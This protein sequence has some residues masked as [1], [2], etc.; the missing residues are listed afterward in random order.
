MGVSRP[1]DGEK[2]KSLVTE[3]KRTN[4]RAIVV[5]VLYYCI[6]FFV[7]ANVFNRPLVAMELKGYNTQH[8]GH[9]G[10]HFSN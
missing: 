10:Q 7:S 6:L 2:K 3:Q 9:A 5:V 4:I 8:S 1:I